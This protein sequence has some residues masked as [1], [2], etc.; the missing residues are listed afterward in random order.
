MNRILY[1]HGFAS[2][3]AS[4]KACFFRR[5]MENRGARVE[6][7]D[8][9]EG[10]FEHLTI[11][12]QLGVIER[13]ANGD[14]V[15]L[16]G[17]SMGGYLAA[18][19]AARHREVARLVLL[20]PAFG[21]ARRWPERLGPDRIA[22]WRRL[23]TMQVFHYGEADMRPLS[24]NLLDDGASYEDYPDFQQPALLFHG[25]KDEVVPAGYSEEFAASHPNA[26]LEV[27]DSGHELTDVVDYMAPKV[28]AFL[29]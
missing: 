12:G 16:I 19:Y 11:T 6:I 24:V 27:L 29:L 10:D 26:T 22:E 1:L 28:A 18:L 20:A 3:P 9:A 25:A 2:G 23:G 13:A 21:F 17:S 8:L 4:G 5:Y 7:P 15:S 14:P